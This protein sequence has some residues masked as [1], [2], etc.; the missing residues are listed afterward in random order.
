MQENKPSKEYLEN[1]DFYKKM[2]IDGYDL[3]TGKKRNPKNAYDG[4]ST[5]IYAK[6]IKN[7]ILKNKIESMLDYGCGKGHYYENAT[8][9]YGIPNK[10]L[11]DFWEI[12]IDLYDPCFEK[13]SHIN[14]NKK[15]DLI[16]CID[17]LEH[18]PSIDID[19]VLKKIINKSNKYVFLN[20]ACYPAV[21]LLPNGKNAHI[22]INSPEWWH[23]KIL[24]LKKN[25]K[26]LKI[27]CICTVKDNGIVKY[28]P[29]QYDDKLINYNT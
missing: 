4:K 18:I 1:L 26:L 9:E 3:V 28:F 16:I 22:N 5:L 15:Y 7:I 27:I 13:N 14:E 8:K 25:N 10:S 12:D 23:K 17:V 11:R 21:A 6:L 19:W 2:H 29:L 20:I 24:N